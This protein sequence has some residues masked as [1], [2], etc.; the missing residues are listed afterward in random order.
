LFFQLVDLLH[1]WPKL[2]QLTLVLGTDDFTENQLQHDEWPGGR[3]E[4]LGTIIVKADGGM[5]T[6]NRS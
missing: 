5:T 3:D 1:D 2:F 6:V 4:I